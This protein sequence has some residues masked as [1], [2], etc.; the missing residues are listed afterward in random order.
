MFLGEG[1]V[2]GE[3]VS[4]LC[5]IIFYLHSLWLCLSQSLFAV[6]DFFL[7]LFAL[8][9]SP[10]R[11]VGFP[12]LGPWDALSCPDFVAQEMVMK[13]VFKGEINDNF[14]HE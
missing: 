4:E 7:P 13:I 10:Y 14:P 9:A 3:V 8:R 11:N 6:W 5:V 1:V 2:E 12:I